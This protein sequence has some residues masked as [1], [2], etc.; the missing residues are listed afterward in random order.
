MCPIMNLC[1]CGRYYVKFG[2]S[3]YQHNNTIPLK[4][5]PFTSIN[6]HQQTHIAYLILVHRLTELTI[7]LLLQLSSVP[8][9]MSSQSTIDASSHFV[10]LS[11]VDFSAVYWRS[12]TASIQPLVFIINAGASRHQRHIVSSHEPVTP[13]SMHQ[14]YHK[15]WAKNNN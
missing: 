9:P 6:H 14:L 8:L 3:G 10:T 12:T 2:H 13:H 7:A 11:P 15:R 1:V 4:S 5:L